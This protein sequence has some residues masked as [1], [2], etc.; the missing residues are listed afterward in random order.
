MAASSLDY[1]FVMSDPDSIEKLGEAIEEFDC[2][3]KSGRI[4]RCPEMLGLSNAEDI[5]AFLPGEN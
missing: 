1:H 3:R 5:K 4:E 2:C